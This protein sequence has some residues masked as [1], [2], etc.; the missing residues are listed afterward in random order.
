MN[1]FTYSIRLTKRLQS[2]ARLGPRGRLQWRLLGI[3]KAKIVLRDRSQHMPGLFS[4][5]VLGLRVFGFKVHALN[6]KPELKTKPQKPPSS[7]DCIQSIEVI[8]PNH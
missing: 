8:T 2:A 4:C 5:R 1:P 7:I 6:S 3:P